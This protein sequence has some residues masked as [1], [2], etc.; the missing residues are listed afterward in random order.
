M[1]SGTNRGF[2]FMNNTTPVA[3]IEGSGN[4]RLTGSLIMNGTTVIDANG[5]WHRSYGNTGWYNGTYGGGMYMTDTTWV[6]TYNG[7][8]LYSSGNFEAVGTIRSVGVYNT[9]IGA[10]NRD[11]YID[12]TGLIGYVSSTLK[13]K[14]NIK[15]IINIDWLLKLRPVT[16]QF[17]ERDEKNNY[18][19]TY[20][21]SLQYGLI[22][23][24][25]EEI[26]PDLCF[27]DEIEGKQELRGINYSK[28][29]TP[30]LKLLQEQQN[31]IDVL[32]ITVKA[33][34]KKLQHIIV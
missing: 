5:G 28:L 20:D 7:K 32:K 2:V 21:N 27:Y 30:M 29:I 9:I 8:G 11:L 4:F 23:E 6:R 31:Q 17:R 12:N 13:S 25:V 24:E 22:A 1:T 14:I 33:L 19:D 3:Q 16:F 15:S 34:M 26:N 10:T 18:L